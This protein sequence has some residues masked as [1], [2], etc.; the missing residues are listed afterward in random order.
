MFQSNAQHHANCVH[1]FPRASSQRFAWQYC[2]AFHMLH[3][4]IWAV[5][6]ERAERGEHEITKDKVD[7]Q[8]ALVSTPTV[9][10]IRNAHASLEG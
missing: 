2:Q 9:T 10:A 4:T 6:M 7:M 3:K 8:Q 5:L 1:R